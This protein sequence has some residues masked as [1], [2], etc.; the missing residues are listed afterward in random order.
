MSRLKFVLSLFVL[1]VLFNGVGCVSTVNKKGENSQIVYKF[2]T[3]SIPVITEMLKENQSTSKSFNTYKSIAANQ[4]IE[5]SPNIKSV[6][7]IIDMGGENHVLYPQV[8]PDGKFI[9]YSVYDKKSNSMNLWKKSVTGMGKTRLTKGRFFDIYP[10]LSKDGKYIFFS[11]NRAGVFNIWRIKVDGGGGLRRITSHRNNDFSPD[12]SPDGNL[13]VFHSYSPFDDQPQIWTCNIN[14]TA[15]TQMKVGKKP[16]WAPDG[17]KIMF[18]AKDTDDN[19]DIWS[20]SKEATETTQFSNGLNVKSACWT[21][22]GQVL[23]SAENENAIKP[24]YDIWL[25]ET[26]LTTNPSD[27]DCPMFD[28]K[29]QLFF[30]SNR[31][32]S[33]DYWMTAEIDID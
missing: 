28:Q 30:R 8:S 22:D 31:G 6:T 12:V 27:D 11:S 14:G 18:I 4:I 17:E 20:M 7:R 16:K 9:I 13:L 2:K 5:E 23:Y 25:N 1:V 3:L 19:W 10:T 32:F 33:V 29:G 15:L 26:Q 21:N 24:N